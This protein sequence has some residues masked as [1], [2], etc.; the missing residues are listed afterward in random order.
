MKKFPEDL[1]SGIWEQSQIRHQPINIKW[2]LRGI[3]HYKHF[4]CPVPHL[5]PKIQRNLQE[6]RE[7]GMDQGC[8]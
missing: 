3:C 4:F 7:H 1:M 5:Q 6:V 8:R 2:K